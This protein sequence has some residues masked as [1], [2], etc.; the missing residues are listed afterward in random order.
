MEVRRRGLIGL[1]GRQL[2]APKH[3]P[4]TADGVFVVVVIVS[5][6]RLKRSRDKMLP[7]K[8]IKKKTEKQMHTHESTCGL[9]VDRQDQEVKRGHGKRSTRGGGYRNR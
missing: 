2:K 4:K 6:E 7:G 3:A 5:A 8:M 9:V 1:R